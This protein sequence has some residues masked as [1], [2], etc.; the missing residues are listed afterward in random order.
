MATTKKNV[1][2]ELRMVWTEKI[3]EWLKA[4]GED[5]LRV[6]S[7][8]LA[9][10]VVGSDGSEDFVIFTVKVPIGSRDGEAYDG[11]AIAEDF[12]LKQ[13]SKAAKRAEQARAKEEKKARDEKAREE[14]R[15]AKEAAKQAKTAEP[16]EA[17]EAEEG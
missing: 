3:S 14:K 13:D 8:E 15:R 16:T 4:S 2:N 5:A 7:N 9:I 6:S 12:K 11:Y 17:T 1:K 10:P